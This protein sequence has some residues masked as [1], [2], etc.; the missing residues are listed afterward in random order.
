LVNTPEE[1]CHID[2]LE[3]SCFFKKYLY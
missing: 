2:S 1:N 3:S